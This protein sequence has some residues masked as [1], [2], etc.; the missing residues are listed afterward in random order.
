[1][2]RGLANQGRKGSIAV[3][4]CVSGDVLLL[5]GTQV[6]WLTKFLGERMGYNAYQYSCCCSS[7]SSTAS[8]DGSTG[9][10]NTKSKKGVGKYQGGGKDTKRGNDS[11]REVFREKQSNYRADFARVKEAP[12]PTKQQWWKPDPATGVYVPEDY[13]GKVTT[14]TTKSRKVSKPIIRSEETTA[15]IDRSWWTSMEEL[16][17]MDRKPL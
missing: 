12:P 1:M 17:D 13:H 11:M 4:H 14:C 6:H 2:I 10:K 7:Y 8:G 3:M 15:R 16:P 9:D 5:A